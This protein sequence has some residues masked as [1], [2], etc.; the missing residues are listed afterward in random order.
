MIPGKTM[1]SNHLGNCNSKCGVNLPEPLRRPW[2]LCHDRSGTHAEGH[3]LVNTAQK[4]YAAS[5]PPQASSVLRRLPLIFEPSGKYPSGKELHKI[6]HNHRD[7]Q[8]LENGQRIPL[9]NIDPQEAMSHSIFRNSL[10]PQSPP[11]S[12]AGS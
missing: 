7:G 12:C 2:E 6:L 8:A 11:H 9:C 5:W 4:S 10:K 3:I 1:S